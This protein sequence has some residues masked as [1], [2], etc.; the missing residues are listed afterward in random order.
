MEVEDCNFR[1]SF[2]LIIID[3][4]IDC[5]ETRICT[6]LQIGLWL[7]LGW[8]RNQADKV[9]QSCVIA[10]ALAYVFLAFHER[11]VTIKILYFSCP[12]YIIEPVISIVWDFGISRGEIETEP[13]RCC[14]CCDRVH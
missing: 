4:M 3:F 2:T 10:L 12:L 6:N 14:C 11:A 13:C 1:T 8:G 9:G 5:R 7:V